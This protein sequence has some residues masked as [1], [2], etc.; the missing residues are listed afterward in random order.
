MG[1]IKAGT[2]AIGS[3]LADQWKEFFYCE[4]LPVDV[5]M[6]KGVKKTGKNTSNTKGSDNVISSGSGIVVADGQCMIIVEQGK[7]VEV[8]A[9][10]GEFTWDASTEP[11]I[12]NGNLADS[13][14]A[15]FKTL[16]KRF[17]FGGDIPKDQRV[18]YFN[19]KELLDN[20]FGTPNPVPFRVVDKNIGLDVDISVRCNGVYSYKINDPVLFYTNV[21][22]NVAQEY[23]RSE[24]D[25]QLKAEFVSGLQP[26]LGRLSELGIRYSSVPAHNMELED[27][28][29]DVLSARWKE[30]RGLSI[31]SVLINSITASKEDEDMIKDLQKTAVMRDPGMAAATLV[32]AQ[33]EAMKTAA[34]NSGGAMIGFMGMNMANAAGG[35]S[36]N[37]LF[38]MSAAQ[39]APVRKCDKC[40]WEPE[41]GANSPKFCPEC[42]DVF[43]GN[44]VK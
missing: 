20:K 12:F 31:V 4:S 5:L 34:G 9:E 40:G 14:M 32:G 7:V 23:R 13:L 41:E 18:Y 2:S 16:G 6:T 37:S 44:D 25:A 43:D 38:E 10:S 24:I 26:A 11:S 8:C 29:N 42:G 35:A 28:L 1:L 22:G 33:A 27:A 19:T 30:R 21:A 39:K 17:T 15:S 3:T 36:T